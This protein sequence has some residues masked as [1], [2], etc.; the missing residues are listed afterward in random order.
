MKKVKNER[1]RSWLMIVA[2]IVAA[3]LFVGVF[4]TI[5]RK[6]LSSYENVS[7]VTAKTEIERGTQITKEN[8]NDLF[9]MTD[10][11]TDWVIDQAVTESED[12]IGCVIENTIHARE[13]VAKQDVIDREEWRGNLD[14]P[15]EFTF[16]A[17]SIADSVGGTI[18]GGDVIDVGI[19]L[20]KSDGISYFESIGREIYVMDVYDDNGLA[21][22]KS[23]TTTVCTMFRV[24]MEK[25]EGE[26][27]LEKLRAGDEVV[28]TLPE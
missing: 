12:L 7:V 28:V 18:R 23:D 8:L 25:A 4:L 15:I 19:V 1:K 22:A 13:M 11:K 24:V 14:E 9:T 21:V 16:T 26:L 3:I 17:S 5:E 2:P 27:F 20:Q 6:V 10:M